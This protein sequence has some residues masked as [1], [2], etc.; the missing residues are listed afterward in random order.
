MTS[1]HNDQLNIF[2]PVL[3]SDLS[4]VPTDG[5]NEPSATDLALRDKAFQS[6]DEYE[7]PTV[8][9]SSLRAHGWTAGEEL[10]LLLE[11]AHQDDNLGIK[12]KAIQE[13]RERRLASRG[14]PI[15]ASRTRRME[16]GSVVRLTTEV[17]AQSLRKE[18]PNGIESIP[19]PELPPTQSTSE[20]RSSDQTASSARPTPPD[21]GIP[22]RVNKPATSSGSAELLRGLS[23]GG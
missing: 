12:L 2:S 11:L 3:P 13:L 16:D 6:L 21:G 1:P 20:D 22:L 14:A 4:P 17:V 23:T 9:V 15:T 8:L 19:E 18:Q 5:P 7:D 10:R